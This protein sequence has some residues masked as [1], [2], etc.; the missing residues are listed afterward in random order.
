MTRIEAL[1]IL[2]SLLCASDHGHEVCLNKEVDEAITL[3]IAAITKLEEV[4]S[5]CQTELAIE[6]HD[7]YPERADAISRVLHFIE[8]KI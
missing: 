4:E 7:G 6:I 5:F 8:E 2:T 3:A 1:N